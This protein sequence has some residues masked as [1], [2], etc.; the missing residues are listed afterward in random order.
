MTVGKAASSSSVAPE[1]LEHARSKA[2]TT[3]YVGWD[4]VAQAALT[5]EDT[6]RDSSRPRSRGCGTSASP[7]TCSPA[8]RPP[9]RAASRSRSAST[10]ANVRADVLPA[11]KHAV[12]DR[13]AGTAARVVAMVGDGVNDA[14]A[15]AQADLGLA[16]GSGTDVAMDSADIVLVRPDLDAV[17]DAI[18]LSPRDPEDHQAEPL[19]AFGY[20]TA[21]IP[22]A[23]FGLLNPMIAGATMALSSV[24]VVTTRCGCALRR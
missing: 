11:D 20:N 6:V 2:G 4:G 15:L 10:P 8:T 7:P 17:G 16:M 23:A 24:L 13:A 21:A 12:V 3:V 1:L 19:W 18:G 9:T 14:A 22:L 5:V